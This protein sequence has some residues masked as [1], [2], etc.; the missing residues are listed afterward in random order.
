MLSLQGNSMQA[1][2]R[3]HDAEHFKQILSEDTVY[4]IENF[5]I[6]PSRNN[7]KVLNQK[8]MIQISK[9]TNVV[10]TQND[11]E[12]IPFHSFNFICFDYIKN[13]RH[14]DGCLLGIFTFW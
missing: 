10:E 7:Y 14:N 13:K 11:V 3:K 12:S 8:Y 1:T 6:I 2:I 4:V 5:N 9:W